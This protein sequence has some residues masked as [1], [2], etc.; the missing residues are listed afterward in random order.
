MECRTA[1]LGSVFTPLPNSITPPLPHVPHR[2]PQR[3]QALR[4]AGRAGRRLAEDRGGASRWSIIGA[5]GTGKSVMLKHIVGLLKPDAGEV[6]FDGRRIDTLPERELVE[7]RKQIRLPLP[8]GRAVRLAQ[9]RGERRVP[10]RRAH[11]QVAGG[12]QPDRGARNCGWSGCPRSARRCR[13]SC[14]AGSE[15]RRAGPRDRAGPAR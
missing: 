8:D 13:P 1:R 15:A 7:V 9:R 6:W 11:A 10:A 14:P 5:S 2:T 4:P 3:S 12:D